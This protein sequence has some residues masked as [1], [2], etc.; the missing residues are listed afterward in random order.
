LQAAPVTGSQIRAQAFDVNLEVLKV[1]LLAGFE[2]R[3]A[4]RTGVGV[5]IDVEMVEVVLAE[6]LVGKTLAVLSGILV[7]VVEIGASDE[8][9]GT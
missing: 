1:E 4:H 6:V 2:V 8:V 5:A 3:T 9:G 7:D